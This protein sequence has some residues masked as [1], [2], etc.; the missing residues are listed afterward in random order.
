MNDILKEKNFSNFLKA[1]FKV[2]IYNALVFPLCVSGAI[3]PVDTVIVLLNKH[4]KI[5]DKNGERNQP[6]K[7]TSS[8]SPWMNNVFINL[9]D[10]C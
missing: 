7:F 5:K 4:N 1:K 3:S 9:L 6:S 8:S 10:I 2:K